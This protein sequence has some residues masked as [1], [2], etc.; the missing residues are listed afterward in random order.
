MPTEYHKKVILPVPTANLT[1]F[2]VCIKVVADTDI[3]AVCRE[4]GFDIHFKAGNGVTEL[5]FER[6]SFAVAAGAATGIFWVKTNV[7]TA[8]TFIFLCYGANTTDSSD[9]QN[10]WDSGFKA[11][12]HM[13]DATTST[14]LD[15]TANNN[16]GTKKGANEPIEAT[17]KIGMG[18][19]FDGADDAIAALTSTSLDFAGDFTLECWVKTTQAGIPTGGFIARM[20]GSYL[21]GYWLKLSSDKARFLARDGTTNGAL[22][23]IASIN[24]DVWRHV[25]GRKTASTLEIYIDGILNNSISI[26]IGAITLVEPLRLGRHSLPGEGYYDGLVDEVRISSIARSAEWIAYEYANMNPAGGGLTWGAQEIKNVMGSISTGLWLG[27]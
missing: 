9:A 26:A 12:Y 24:N 19:D 2:P 23:S 22:P 3:G 7:S 4:D 15:S 1:D 20:D 8:G 6:E 10:T 14:I 27:V 5:K 18:Q 21:R 16:D 11:V 13:N 17:G 25:V